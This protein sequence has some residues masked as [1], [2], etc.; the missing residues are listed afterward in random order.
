MTNLD[1]YK[2]SKG[3][4]NKISGG[5]KY[6]CHASDIALN[7][8]YEGISFDIAFYDFPESATYQDAERH[9]QTQLGSDFYVICN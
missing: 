4:M 3:Q 9:L 2:L 5:K 8:F 6:V 1:S 7:G